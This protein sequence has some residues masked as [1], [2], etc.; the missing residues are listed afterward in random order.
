MIENV[1]RW[2]GTYLDTLK[3]RGDLDNTLIVY[4]SDHGEM[5]GDHS[6]WGKS[7]HYRSASAVPLI[8]S[9]PGIK[10]RGTV[11]APAAILDLAA[12]F[13]DYAGVTVPDDWDSLSLKGFLEGSSEFPRQVAL[14]GL[15]R[16]RMAFDGRY[17]LVR[18]GEDKIIL[19]DL[20][21]DPNEDHNIAADHEKIVK[22][23][24]PRLSS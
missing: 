15:N 17:K 18:L 1:D 12:T 24:L 20:Q 6:R 16:F 23:L 7:I 9:G 2:L 21:E 13:V 14:S 19:Y 8:V 22:R 10:P 3:T 4:S 11:D 5:L